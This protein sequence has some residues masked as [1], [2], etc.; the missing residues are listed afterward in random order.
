MRLPGMALI[1]MV[2]CYQLLVS[3]WLGPCCRFQPTCSEYL[4]EAIKRYGAVGGVR[5]S[6]VRVLRCH[7]WGGSGYDPP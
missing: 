2:R 5:R 1:A 7:P 3:P 4:I 6:I